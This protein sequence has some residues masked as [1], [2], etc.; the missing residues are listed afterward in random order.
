[1]KTLFAKSRSLMNQKGRGG[2]LRKEI[3]ADR[4]QTIKLLENA[5]VEKSTKSMKKNLIV[6]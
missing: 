4:N 2:S 1:M 3:K 6:H 5:G